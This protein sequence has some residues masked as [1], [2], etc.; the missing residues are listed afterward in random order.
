M[1]FTKKSNNIFLQYL[2]TILYT[3]FQVTPL[4]MILVKFCYNIYILFHCTI[5]NIEFYKVNP[6]N[7]I[8]HASVFAP[9]NGWFFLLNIQNY[10][11]K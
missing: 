10:T 1:Q 2:N 4:F 7:K 11:T 8:K 3:I 9:F 5:L 6:P